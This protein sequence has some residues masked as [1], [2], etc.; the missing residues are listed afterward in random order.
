MTDDHALATRPQPAKNTVLEKIITGISIASSAVPVVGGPTSGT[1]NTWVVRMQQRRWKDYWESV[2]VR[3]A[4][5]ERTVAAEKELGS[6]DFLRRVQQIHHQVIAEADDNKM[7]YL[8]DFLV[9]AASNAKPDSTWQDIF[10]DHVSRL[11]GSHLLILKHF[12]SLQ[13]DLSLVQRFKL[14]QPTA[15]SPLTP[16]KIGDALPAYDSSLILVLSA[17][18]AA[19]GLLQEWSTGERSQRGWSITDTG[20]LLMRFLQL[21]WRIEG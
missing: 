15:S 19:R 10:W 5:L 17:D 20:L 14:P 2:E 3:V 4:E 21:E 16:Q 12:Y 8:R 13:K 18:L 1:L 6:E 9:G 7:A 11:T